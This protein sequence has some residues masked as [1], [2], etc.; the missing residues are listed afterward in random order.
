MREVKV[1]L[2]EARTGR[3]SVP[4]G[5]WAAAATW[6]AVVGLAATG[7][8]GGDWPH[9]R[10]PNYDGISTETGWLGEWGTGGP[11][12]VWKASAGTGFTTITVAKG[13]AY[14]MGNTGAKP[15]QDIVF[16]WD[17]L[18]GKEVWRQ[19]YEAALEKG[20]YEG[21]PSATPTVDGELVYTFGKKGQL[22]CWEAG[23][24]KAVWSRNVL[25][26]DKMERPG[27][28]YASSPLVQGELV[29]L[30]A[31][32][33]GAAYRKTTGAPMW[34]TAGKGAGHA[35]PVPFKLG[36]KDVLALMTGREFMAVETAT[37]Q[38][39]GRMA[40]KTQ[41]DLNPADPIVA[42]DEAFISAGY[43]HGCARVKFTGDSVKNVW[44]NKNLRNHVN[45][46]V[47]IGG[48]LYGFDGQ[49]LGEG[50]LKCL[51]WQTG[52]VKWSQGGLGT[53]SLTA[54]DGKLI[55]LGEKGT[56]VIVEAS[57]AGYK[58]LR[59][60]EVLQGKCWTP[61]VLAN[62]KIYVRNAA[63]EV[64]CLDPQGP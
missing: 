63:G 28:G 31:G 15:E 18:T 38:P 3:K 34:K 40:W 13:R 26:Q 20:N 53:G 51:D 12:V 23:T 6:A 64:L 43:G 24:G 35:T 25:E 54:A 41:Y 1:M 14:T 10:G 59:R 30:N 11:K 8:W 9:W 45:S 32:P 33:Q 56:L 39:L 58:E 57:P 44:E 60:A 61:P 4:G 50:D 7:A 37:G 17:A 42:G 47:L 52:Q 62:G 5:A 19:G 29:I 16:C 55:V 36:G 48:C 21:G 27:W 22:Y 49:V 46:S 2:S